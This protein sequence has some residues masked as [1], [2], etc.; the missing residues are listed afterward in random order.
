VPL[1]GTV[2][3]WQVVFLLAGVA[4]LPI[5]LLVATLMEPKRRGAVVRKDAGA[6]GPTLRDVLIYLLQNKRVYGP[7]FL[8]LCLTSLHLFGLA[9]WNAAFY[10][11][12]YGWAPATVGLYAGLL[13]L[14]LALPA[15][16]GA[17]WFND[18]FRKKGHADADMRVLAIGFSSAAP[19]M[20]LGPLMPSP[21]LALSMLGIGSAFMLLAAP[22][23]NSAM[24][25]VT[26]NNM[27]G[28]VT[29]LYM[30]TMFAVGG[31]VGP[32][33]FAFLTQHIWG[34]EKLLNYAIATSAALLVPAASL[35]Y[36]AGVKP[37]R[38]RIL[39]MRAVDALS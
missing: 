16:A 39:E 20:I 23:L 18:L 15:L 7:I 11:R 13:N 38:E 14:G 34:D 21:W 4:G 27:R 3:D 26:P 32:T 33:W 31:S 22:S 29:A 30:F 12:T 9:A 19:F 37:Y 2:R 17:V 25:I 35:I 6:R 5:T 10:G 8:G 28:R 24:Q 1:L 36:W